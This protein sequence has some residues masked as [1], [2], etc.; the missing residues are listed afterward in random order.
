MSLT[1]FSVQSV[2]SGRPGGPGG[3]KGSLIKMASAGPSKGS[4]SPSS[5]RALTLNLSLCPVLRFPILHSRG[6]SDLPAGFHTPSSI[7]I[8]S[9]IYPII[10]V[11]PSSRG[12]FQV[13]LQPSLWTSLTIAVEGRPLGGPGGARTV[14]STS[15]SSSPC[16][17]TA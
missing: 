14:N 2:I 6:P 13:S 4:D 16:S 5:L 9:M 10:G 11:P 12:S 17:L 7:S 15:S 3:S 1:L 8:F